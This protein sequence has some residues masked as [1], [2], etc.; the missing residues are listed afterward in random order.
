MKELKK[1]L[2]LAAAPKPISIMEKAF[3]DASE[4][5]I[6]EHQMP[7]ILQ[8]YDDRSTSEI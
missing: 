5:A 2:E 1:S 3:N 4:R 8:R 7:R 6:I